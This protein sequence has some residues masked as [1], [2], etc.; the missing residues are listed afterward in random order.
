MRYPVESAGAVASY[1]GERVQRKLVPDHVSGAHPAL[2]ERA[3]AVTDQVQALRDTSERLVREHGVGIKDRQAQLK[4]L[5]HAAIEAY[6]QIATISRVTDV[7]DETTTT[8]ELGE[9]AF[10]ADTFC[11]RAARRGERWLHQ[12][13]DNDDEAMR[14][15]ATAVLDRGGYRHSI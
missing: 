9:E 5:T 2:G 10:I 4:R 8:Q 11:R 6:A 15:I 12:T 3:D 13:E 1:L 7:L 14:R